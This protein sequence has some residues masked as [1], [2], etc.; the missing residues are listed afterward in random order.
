M[1]PGDPKGVAVIITATPST[2]AGSS[3]TGWISTTGS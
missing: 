3:P 2:C 1:V